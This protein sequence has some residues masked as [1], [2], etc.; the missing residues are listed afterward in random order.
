MTNSAPAM[1]PRI[2]T[3]RA[4]CSVWC[5]CL[6]NSFRSSSRG[7]G[8]APLLLPIHR[9][10]PRRSRFRREAIA[11]AYRL[12]PPSIPTIRRGRAHSSSRVFSPSFTFTSIR[13]SVLRPHCVPHHRTRPILRPHPCRPGHQ[14]TTGGIEPLKGLKGRVSLPIEPAFNR[15]QRV[16]RACCQRPVPT[17][18][19]VLLVRHRASPN[20]ADGNRTRSTSGRSIDL[21]NRFDRVASLP[22]C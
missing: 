17:G 20:A 19:V 2:A 21:R 8:L 1:D 4:S 18:L 16:P 6:P 22:R 5:Q 11:L 10:R 14:N 15:M 7:L 12:R 13:F 9:R 3:I